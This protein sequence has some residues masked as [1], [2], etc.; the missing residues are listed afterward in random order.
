MGRSRP[1]C[2][3]DPSGL[4]GGG[5]AWISHCCEPPPSTTPSQLPAQTVGSPPQEPGDLSP[6]HSRPPPHPTQ[7]ES[8]MET[9]GPLPNPLPAPT[10]ARPGGIL[11]GN[12]GA[13][14]L[15]MVNSGGFSTSQAPV[16]PGSWQGS[17]KRGP[18]GQVVT[19][20]GGP[21]GGGCRT[22]T[23]PWESGVDQPSGE[24]WDEAAEPPSDLWG[25][26]VVLSL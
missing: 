21:R 5:G 19:S 15:C 22:F 8:S 14:L 23:F 11:H 2:S 6:T 4:T 12:L 24:K 13:D 1:S 9:W 25:G 18:A 16:E 10:L 26:S 7:G 3:L 20:V 17:R